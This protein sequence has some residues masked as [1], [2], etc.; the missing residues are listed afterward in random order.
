MSLARGVNEK[1]RKPIITQ[2]RLLKYIDAID[3]LCRGEVSTEYVAERGKKLK[4][5]RGNKVVKRG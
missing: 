4:A 2:H 3:K 5:I 1:N